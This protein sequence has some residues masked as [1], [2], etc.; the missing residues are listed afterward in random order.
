[1]EA[2]IFGIFE[3]VTPARANAMPAFAS[4]LVALGLAEDVREVVAAS[5][6]EVLSRSESVDETTMDAVGSA[7]IAI[8]DGKEVQTAQFWRKLFGLGDGICVDGDPNDPDCPP[9]TTGATPGAQGGG[10]NG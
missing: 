1:V 9:S 4:D 7:I 3:N 6:I 10:Y 8:L 5:M 2:A